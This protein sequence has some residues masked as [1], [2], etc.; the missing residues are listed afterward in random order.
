M[1]MAGPGGVPGYAPARQI[2]DKMSIH[3][4]D[5]M[6]EQGIREAGAFGAM[7][8]QMGGQITQAGKEVS[9]FLTNEKAKKDKI[10]IEQAMRK[11]KENEANYSQDQLENNNTNPET[12]EYEPERMWQDRDEFHSGMDMDFRERLSPEAY[13]IVSRNISHANEMNKVKDRGVRAKLRMENT[14][15]KYQ[16]TIN[17]G[18]AEA[19]TESIANSIWAAKERAKGNARLLAK[20][21][22]EIMQIGS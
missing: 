19:T 17:E 18:V 14:Y 4:M 13:N 12:N 20:L 15:N 6:F 10:D 11:Y 2:G 16:E 8:R 5:S 9:A 1:T 7:G 21:P 3:A 22:N